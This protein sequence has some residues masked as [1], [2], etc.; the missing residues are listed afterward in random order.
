[1]QIT[2]HTLQTFE[3]HALD[4]FRAEMVDHYRTSFPWHYGSWGPQVTR[5]VVDHGLARARIYGLLAQ[6]DVCTYLTLL[7]MLGG[8]FDEDQL[9]PWAREILIDPRIREP[10]VRITRLTNDAMEYLDR[11][12]GDRNRLLHRALLTIRR[13]LANLVADRS[14]PDVFQ[15]ARSLLERI[16]LRK[17]ELHGEA[18]IDTLIHRGVL[19]AT[20]YGFTERCGQLL[21]IVLMFICGSGFDRDPQLPAFEPILADMTMPNREQHFLHTCLQYVEKWRAAADEAIMGAADV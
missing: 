20:R 3:A 2:K 8:C 19:D 4:S 18:A 7:P 17:Y 5:K 13:D 21:F 11:L 1:M 6:R 14:E 15:Q 9:I 16:Y 10:V 12:L